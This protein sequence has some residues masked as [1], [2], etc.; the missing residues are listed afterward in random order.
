M[1][2][3]S[4]IKT[5]RHG[6]ISEICDL[7]NS[8]ADYG[9]EREPVVYNTYDKNAHYLHTGS[10]MIYGKKQNVFE[11]IYDCFT[12]RLVYQLHD[13]RKSIFQYNFIDSIDFSLGLGIVYTLTP[14]CNGYLTPAKKQGYIGNNLP[15]NFCY[16]CRHYNYDKKSVEDI[17][18]FAD[19]SR[20]EPILTVTQNGERGVLTK[21]RG[22]K[23]IR[24]IQKIYKG[25]FVPECRI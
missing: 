10:V 21:N 19:A 17:Q 14:E 22:N 1:D 13:P 25:K 4:V 12:E 20:I 15:E 18:L 7:L 2:F 3:I 8:F 11:I 9:G 24:G 23:I 5:L 6:T 16:Y